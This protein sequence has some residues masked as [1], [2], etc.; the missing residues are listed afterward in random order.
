MKKNVA[1]IL[2]LSLV[3]T[4]CSCGSSSGSSSNSIQTEDTYVLVNGTKQPINYFNTLNDI[5][6]QD[7]QNSVI[8][9]RSKLTEVHG[10]T[11]FQG[12][13]AKVESYLDLS[14]DGSNKYLVDTSGYEDI[15]KNWMPGDII[16]ATGTIMIYVNEITIFRKWAVL[17][18]D[19]TISVKNVTRNES[20]TLVSTLDDYNEMI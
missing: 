16:E 1:L 19:G 12:L 5:Q 4:F 8:T 18:G 13:V 6:I 3:L 17:S 20:F 15:V 9:V 2:M 14:G 7:L 11:Y 10:S